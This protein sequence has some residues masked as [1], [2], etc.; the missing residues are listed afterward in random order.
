MSPFWIL[1]VIGIVAVLGYVGARRRAMASASG[2]IRNLH[3][4]PN[5]YGM[6]A[7]LA[8][9]VPALLLLAV[10]SAVQ[11]IV[12]KQSVQS[13]ILAENP[14]LGA[15]DLSLVMTQVQRLAE[16]LSGAMG[17]D[18]LT[19]GEVFDMRADL[20]NVRGRLA[21]L[22]VAL[23]GDVTQTELKAAQ[24]YLGI[25]AWGD[26]MKTIAVIAVSLIGTAIAFAGLLALVAWALWWRRRPRT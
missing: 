8:G 15:G 18:E 26:T 6:N 13:I 23:S 1:I 4:L 10:W 22:G 2:N 20:T 11:P 19:R 25:L 21:D 12:I 9:L 5:F 7:L 17:R 3:S 24:R 14:D 16:G